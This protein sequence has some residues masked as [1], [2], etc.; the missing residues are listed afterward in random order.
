MEEYLDMDELCKRLGFKKRFL[1]EL[2]HK[3]KIPH[4]KIG[5][6]LRFRWD[7]IKKWVDGHEI[8]P[9]YDIPRKQRIKNEDFLWLR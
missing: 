6:L 9:T 1:Y 7:S 8:K 2:T 5:R 4:I 3:G